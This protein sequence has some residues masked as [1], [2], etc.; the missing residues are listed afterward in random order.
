MP[1]WNDRALTEVK[2]KV[3][4]FEDKREQV[5]VLTPIEALDL[6]PS[7]VRILQRYSVNSV[8]TLTS[9]TRKDLLNDFMGIG[10]IRTKRI[11][12]CLA[13]HGLSLA[14][15]RKAKTDNAA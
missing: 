12:Q 14:N 8:E 9:L 5:T 11:K 2:Q 6:D 3:S 7:V 13:E 4:L 15:S 1:T 10:S